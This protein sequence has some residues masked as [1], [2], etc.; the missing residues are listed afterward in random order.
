M[1]SARILILTSGPLCRNPRPLKE[2]L[3][4]AAAGYVVTVITGFE[5]E[6]GVELDKNLLAGTGVEFVPLRPAPGLNGFMQRARIALARRAVH[7]FGWQLPSSLG[8]AT[9]LLA[10]ARQ[11]DSD[12]IIAH[13]ESALWAASHL[14]TEGRRVAA[15]LEDWYSED[16]L[17]AA[18]RARPIPLL[19]TLEKAA[20]HHFAYASTTSEALATA[21]QKAHGGPLAHVVPNT[22]HLQPL[23][24]PVLNATPSLVWFSQ[25]VGPGRGLEAFLHIWA[26][27]LVPS[28]LVLVGHCCADFR[29]TLAVELPP[30]KLPQ[31]EF[32]DFVAAP[33]LPS[34]LAQHDIGLALEPHE[35]LNKE[36]TTSNKIYQYLNAGLAVLAT[37]TAGQREVFARAPAIGQLLDL[38]KA[39]QTAAALD[40]FLADRSRLLACR[41]AARAAA[42]Q[43]FCWEKTAPILLAAVAAALA[44]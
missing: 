18:R 30:E 21:L 15:D 26:Q 25:T 3:T 42:E 22:F 31:L 4:L 41:H 32:V 44:R 39:T 27:S 40:A 9:A 17:P 20:L 6:T 19:R 14:H 33:L 2:A 23:S 7:R 16:L 37:P 34:L 12:L 43:Y 36:Y 8:P 35:P 24:E 11:S 1:P 28:R 10:R 5:G 13:N 38:A 29:R